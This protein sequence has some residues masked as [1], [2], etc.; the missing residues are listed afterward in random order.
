MMERE[1][2][3]MFLFSS[4][5]EAATLK[6]VLNRDKDT[7][8][9]EDSRRQL[10]GFAKFRTRLEALAAKDIVNGRR[11]DAEKG[12]ILK[13]EMA[14]KN[15]H[16]KHLRSTQ[17]PVYDAAYYSRTPIFLPPS[18]PSTTATYFPVATDMGG[19]NGLA[20]SNS[21]AMPLTPMPEHAWHT[22]T[23]SPAA[24]LGG[25]HAS[26]ASPSV[27]QTPSAQDDPPQPRRASLAGVIFNHTANEFAAWTS[28]PFS[29]MPTP[30][31]TTS[32]APIV[33]LPSPAASTSN[34]KNEYN[35]SLSTQQ[36]LA[37]PAWPR[38]AM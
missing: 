12:S 6:L 36:D 5:F 38:I 21:K 3:N 24:H 14:K 9:D 7:Q 33:M 27:A 11:I 32:P 18:V 26:F 31:A 19:A 34:P 22:A 35:S 29:L 17:L 28:Q 16:I 4:G 20:G 25:R 37:T 2:Q 13:A 1:F 30:A 8:L 23:V 10:I 15:L